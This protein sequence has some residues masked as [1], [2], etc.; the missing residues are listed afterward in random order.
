MRSLVIV[1]QIVDNNSEHCRLASL[2]RH[3]VNENI[4]VRENIATHR[5]AIEAIFGFER[6]AI[7]S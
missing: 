6:K 5:I 4:T 2:G 3:Y 1:Q 7:L